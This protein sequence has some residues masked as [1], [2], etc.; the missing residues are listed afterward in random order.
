MSPITAV[1]RNHTTV[2]AVILVTVL[3]MRVEAGENGQGAGGTYLNLIQVR[4]QSACFK[5]IT[6]GLVN[7][8]TVLACLLHT[9]TKLSLHSAVKYSPS[10]HYVNGYVFNFL[11]LFIKKYASCM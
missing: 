8:P 4:Q 11:Y 2:R 10:N 6:W 1:R 7:Q 5:I 3:E 9:G